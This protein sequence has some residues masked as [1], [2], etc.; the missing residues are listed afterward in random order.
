F[1]FNLSAS[2]L[3]P[4]IVY[5]IVGTTLFPGGDFILPA[6]LATI[7]SFFIAATY[8][9]LTASFP[10]SG[11]DY[12]FNS[13]ILHPAIGFGMNFSLTLWEWFIAGFYI[14]FV[15]SSGIS[16]TLVIVG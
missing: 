1:I 6:L 15:A 12:I 10:R 4:A 5:M 7:F 2:P 16:P 8:A 11:G 9:Q 14:F 13:R 3:G